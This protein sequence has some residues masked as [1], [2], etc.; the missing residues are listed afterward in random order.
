METHG[1]SFRTYF[2]HDYCLKSGARL[3]HFSTVS[4][5]LGFFATI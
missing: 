2:K 5:D 3:V 4:E 1:V